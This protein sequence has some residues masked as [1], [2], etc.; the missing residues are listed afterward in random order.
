[1]K[2]KFTGAKNFS[3]VLTMTVAPH[4]ICLHGH[5][6]HGTPVNVLR[7]VLVLKSCYFTATMTV[8]RQ[9]QLFSRLHIHMK[10]CR[11]IHSRSKNNSYFKVC[12]NVII[13][14]WTSC[15]LWV[16]DMKKFQYAKSCRNTDERRS[17]WNIL[18]IHV[19]WST[20]TTFTVL[21]ETAISL[22][23]MVQSMRWHASK[24][25]SLTTAWKLLS[26]HATKTQPIQH[27]LL[28]LCQSDC[29]SLLFKMLK[30]NVM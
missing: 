7:Y 22:S 1:M 18:S 4:H 21:N 5:V 25:V 2:Q 29:F 13:T 11:T 3:S 26:S 17:A 23:S 16:V 28:S 14:W 6:S 24:I 20:Q 19:A 10:T 15:F 12:W 9:Q 27:L 8:S 30:I